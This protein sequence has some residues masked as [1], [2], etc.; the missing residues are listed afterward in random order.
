M[1]LINPP[2]PHCVVLTPV[3]GGESGCSVIAGT[4]WLQFHRASKLSPWD[5]GRM[6]SLEKWLNVILCLMRGALP[7]ATLDPQGSE[8]TEGVDKISKN[9][10]WILNPYYLITYPPPPHCVVLAPV[11]GGESGCSVIA[12]TLSPLFPVVTI[13]LSCRGVRGESV[14]LFTVCS[15]IHSYLYSVICTLYSVLCHL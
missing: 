14:L 9:V 13:P 11:P 4:L 7:S 10:K 5:R 15:H 8:A 3:S 1:N 12:G 6:R 2:P